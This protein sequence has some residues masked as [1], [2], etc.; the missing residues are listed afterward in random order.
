M[1]IA[2]QFNKISKKYDS[3]RRK[4][5]PCFEEFYEKT[6]DFVAH[7]IKSPSRILDLGAGTGLLTGFWYQHF[8]SAEYVLTDIA[9][10]MLKVAKL[11]FENMSNVTFEISDYRLELPKHT[12]DVI[13]SAL[14]IHHLE[15]D[16]KAALFSSIFDKLPTG[17]VFINYDQF[18]GSTPAMSST[19]DSYWINF[20]ETNGLSAEEI[21]KWKARR[22]LDRECS[23]PL[24][25]EMLKIAGFQTIE[26]IFSMQKFA[27]IMA[28][29]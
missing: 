18:C 25:R 21:K 7:T 5:I 17:G 23:V 6:T 27:V 20:L 29:K 4:F 19:Y 12:F 24:E 28:I 9:E 15:H 10:E 16:E 1:D 11:R 13:M 22:L 3:G 2:E 14:S 26:C 8:S